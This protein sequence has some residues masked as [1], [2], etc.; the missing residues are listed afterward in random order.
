[1]RYLQLVAATLGVNIGGNAALE[2]LLRAFS[3]ACPQ[4]WAATLN[5]ATRLGQD[6]IIDLPAGPR[7]RASLR[8]FV[9][10]LGDTRFDL[11]CNREY[12]PTR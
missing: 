3:V 6:H 11:R 4:C 12:V 7:D 1:M 5:E 9:G 8:F 10:D 2:Q